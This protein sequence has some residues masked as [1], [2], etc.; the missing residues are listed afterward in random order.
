MSGYAVQ[1]SNGY[2]MI[3]TETEN[4]DL[5]L[6]RGD[7]ADWKTVYMEGLDDCWAYIEDKGEELPFYGTVEN[8]NIVFVGLNLVYHCTLT[9]DA[10]ATRLLSKAMEPITAQNVPERTLVPVEITY[11]GNHI[12]IDTEYNNVNTCIAYH[13][14]F[15]VRDGRE[16]RKNNNL[17]Y[18]DAGVTEID[19]SFPYFW[20]G[21][22]VTMVGVVLAAVL[23]V[24]AN[25][26]E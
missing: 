10:V 9:Q 20:Q 2:P 6:F 23:L 16:V 15:D 17:T 21:M 3:V 25:R 18:V 24:L 11:S 5:D 4:L 8:E 13:D 14:N 22:A 19:L 26:K 1:F 12:R 7:H